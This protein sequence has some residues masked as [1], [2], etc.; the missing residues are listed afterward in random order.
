MQESSTDPKNGPV[1]LG[2]MTTTIKSCLRS[3]SIPEA[4]RRSHPILGQL[5]RSEERSSGARDD[6]GRRRQSNHVC[7]H[8]LFQ[9]PTEGAIPYGTAQ[10]IRRTVQWR[11][12]RR[13]TTTTIESCLRSPSISETNRRSHPIRDSSTDRKNGPVALGTTTDDDDNQIMFAIAVYFRDQQKEPSHT[14][15]LNRSE[16]RSSGARDDDGRRRQSNH[17]CD[18]R[19][20]QRPTEGAIPYGTAQPIRRTVQWRSGRRRQSNHVC[21]RRLF[22]RP[23]EGAIPFWDS[24]TD[25]KNGPVALGTTADDDDNQIMFAIAVYPRGQQKEPSHTGQLNR[26]N[27]PVALRTTTDDDDNQIMF[28]IAVYFRDQQKEPSHT[29]QLNRSEERSSGA[30]DD[31][32]RRRQSNHVCDRR[33]S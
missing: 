33:L 1:A 27:G 17:V 25:R 2:T 31:D 3:P 23:T 29:G 16:E 9:R 4:N 11:S 19:L 18:R 14:G 26:K 20:F 24:S 8:R 15:Q 12:G 21:D 30:R 7:D 10:P 5:N 28:A 13:R 6:G 22:Q 32:G